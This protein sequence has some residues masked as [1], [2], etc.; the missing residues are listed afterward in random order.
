MNTPAH[1]TIQLSICI[2]TFNRGSI[3]YQTLDSISTQLSPQIELLVVDGASTDDTETVMS[4][5]CAQNPGVRYI[6]ETSNSGVDADFDKAI[7]YARGEYCWLMTDD[8]LLIPGAVQ[9]VLE[10]I[11]SGPDLV[12]VDAEVLN[13]D[14]TK[15]LQRSRMS[16]ERDRY[17]DEADDSFL[18]LAGD[19]LSFIASVII[20]RE[21][22]LDRD[23]EPYYGSLFIHCGVIFQMP[24]LQG[25]K[26]L[27]EPLIQIRYGNAMW[28]PRSF[29]IWM[30]IWP[31]LIWGFPEF[32]D[33]AKQAVCRREP[34]RNA[35]ELFKHRAKGSYSFAEY[36]KY[37]QQR[38]SGWDK[39]RAVLIALTPAVLANFLAVAFV[40]TISRQSR[41]GLSDL[42][43]SPHATAA[44]R[45]LSR[46]FPL[47]DLNE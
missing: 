5:Y 32:N 40:I 42:L 39:L 7:S 35:M 18:T 24:A 19:T 1:S 28:T 14:F 31:G 20:R 22:W 2:A 37:L 41:L 25:I 17:F 21:V 29:E 9:R 6:R 23:R 33:D 15:L 44:S 3:I 36:R 13:I 12:L 27:A 11:A 43:D 45:W 8:D 38:A 47:S 16:L 46:L 26:V 30:F 34:W 4:N 10:E